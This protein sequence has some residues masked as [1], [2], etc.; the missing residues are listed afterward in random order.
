MARIRDPEE[1]EKEEKRKRKKKK[2][3]KRTQ[4]A[5]ALKFN[6]N[7]GT[8]SPDY[9]AVALHTIQYNDPRFR[10]HR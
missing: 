7:P 2:E 4:S 8:L 3:N 10:Y 9:E 1:E 5:L 6:F